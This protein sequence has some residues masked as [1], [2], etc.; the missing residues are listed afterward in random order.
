MKTT[1]L[2]HSWRALGQAVSCSWASGTAMVSALLLSSA[3]LMATTVT[4]ISGGP[5]SGYVNGDTAQTALFH[6]PIG[7]ALDKTESFLFV[8]DRDNNAIRRLDLSG[9]LTVTFATSGVNKPVGVAVDSTGNV[10]VLNRGN[11]SNGSLIEFDS[12]GNPLGT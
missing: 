12:F 4:T 1:Q 3:Q 9:N 5:S 7:L 2:K 6:T 8:A 11:G 10:F